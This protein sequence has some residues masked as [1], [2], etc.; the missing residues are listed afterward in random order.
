MCKYAHCDCISNTDVNNI[1]TVCCF[2]LWHLDVFCIVE[3]EKKKPL[4]F[5][6]L[7]LRDKPMPKHYRYIFALSCCEV[8]FELAVTIR[9][10]KYSRGEYCI[11]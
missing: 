2:S 3:K 4:G 9:Y 11:V 7:A 8:N 6:T 10:P 5:S 1:S